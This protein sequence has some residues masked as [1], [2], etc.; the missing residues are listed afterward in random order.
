MAKTKYMVITSMLDP[1]LVDSKKEALLLIQ[2][3]SLDSAADGELAHTVYK[4]SGELKI[5][6]ISRRGIS[7]PTALT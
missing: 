7:F 2:D 3:R 5:E 1:I 6:T 4:V